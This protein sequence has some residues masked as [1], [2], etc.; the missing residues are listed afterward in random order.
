MTTGISHF[1]K[2]HIDLFPTETADDHYDQITV[3][4]LT[5]IFRQF[6]ANLYTD[7][8]QFQEIHIF[9]WPMV[10]NIAQF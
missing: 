2:D 3:K 8:D 1:Q 4:D 6:V 10:L 7:G 9:F 5:C